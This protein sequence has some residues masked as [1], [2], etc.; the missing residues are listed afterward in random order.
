M[1]PEGLAAAIGDAGDL[2]AVEEPGHFG[3][4][5][6]E[7]ATQRALPLVA[8]YFAAAPTWVLEVRDEIGSGD[9][10]LDELSSFVRMRVALAAA[11]ELE[12]VLGRMEGRASFKYAREHEYS[13]GSLRGKLDVGRYMQTRLLPEAPRRYPVQVIHRRYATPENALAAYAA[14]WVSHELAVAPIHLIPDSAP[15]RRE[16]L[17]R[18]ASLAR[19]LRQPVLVDA[20]DLAMQTRRRRSLAELLDRVEA[21]IEGGHIAASD[22]YA[23][24]VGWI[25]RFNPEAAV[26]EPGSVPWVFY[27]DRFDSKLFELWTLALL[28]DAMTARLGS[29]SGGPRP[30]YERNQLPIATWNLGAVKVLVYFQAALARLGVPGL[31]WHFTEPVAGQLGG[32]PDLGI[33]VERLGADPGLILVDPKLR[34]RPRAPTDEIYKL[35]GYFGNLPGTPPPLG[36]IVFYS[37]GDPRVYRLEDEAGG[38]L[39][40]IAVDPTDEAAATT[41]FDHL[42]QLVVD[43][44]GVSEQTIAK[45]RS[46]ADAGGGEAVEV[47]T[48]VRQE[49]AVEA[50]LAAAQALPAPTL[51][52]VRKSTAA[53]L[54]E[55]WDLLSEAA[56]TMVVTAEYFGQ[57]AP[58]DA[59]H[60]GPLL[61]LGAAC[62][63]V[64]Y[65]SVFDEAIRR[66]PHAFNDGLTLGSLIHLLGI[67]MRGHARFPDGQAVAEYLVELN[68]NMDMLRP[69]V[70]DLRKLNVDY[71]IPAAHSDVVSQRLWVNGR[72]FILS[73]QTGVLPRLLQVFR[74]S[75]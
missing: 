7:A 74:D 13:L 28:I 12:D 60:S 18:R 10:A 9:P 2:V 6:R 68:V 11:R 34:I 1:T 65:E 16:I 31:R 14:L 66:D 71:R 43:V 39:L 67:A 37:P 17:D 75:P 42:A 15:E 30:L 40:A 52:P 45:L 63:R 21:R 36:A 29:V 44:V 51:D 22:T 62:E 59:D 35:L 70:A 58:V 46:A 27:D 38:H 55:V 8:T 56:A 61:G 47:G 73:P 50:M 24:I 72:A 23:Q 64:L 57:N 48:Q 5:A 32:I 33:V 41:L 4:E 49:A 19:R 3:P 53:N 26:P 69:V 20:T 54:H 25:R